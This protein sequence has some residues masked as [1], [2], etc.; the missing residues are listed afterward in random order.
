MKFDF[1]IGNPPYQ[2]DNDNS[3]R[4][5][6]IYNQFMDAAYEIADV[7]ELITPGRFLFDAG[8]TPKV[9]NEKMLND[10]HFKVLHYEKDASKI[11]QN[12]DIKGGVVISVRDARRNFG[13]ISVFTPY[14]EL[15]SIYRKVKANSAKFMDSIVSQRGMYRLTECFF[16]DYP[17]AT[18]RVGTGTGNMIVSN[19]FEKIPE[20][21]LENKPIDNDDYIKVFGRANNSRVFRYIK[22]RYVTKNEYIPCYKV[23]FAEANSSGQFGEIL[24][25]PAIGLPNEGATDT[26][27]NIGI[28]NTEA[29]ARSVIR[30]IQTKFLRALLGIKKATQHTPRSVW[31]TIPLQDFTSQSDID[32]SKSI[33]EIDQQLYVKYGLSKEEIDFIETN[34]KEMA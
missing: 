26:F 31:D 11:F 15:N 29:E 18:K 5:N 22:A 10:N 27:I 1:C 9:W 20:A 32:W 34:V 25:M 12:T 28:L 7:V 3:V 13:K 14:A 2:E 19:I 8:Q 16:S 23:F 4:K 6:P 33:H 30:Y 21:F 17:D 24:S